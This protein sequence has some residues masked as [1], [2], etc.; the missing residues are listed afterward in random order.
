MPRSV[1]SALAV[2]LL[3]ALLNASATRA[4]DDPY[5]PKL[6]EME[7]RIEAALEKRVKCEWENVQLKDVIADLSKQVDL[8]ISFDPE[9]LEEAGAADDLPISLSA[10]TLRL[11]TALQLILGPMNLAGAVG[12]GG[13]EISSQEKVAER[14]ILRV[15]P[16]ADLI[17][18]PNAGDGTIWD[19]DSLTDAITSHVAPDAWPDGTGPGPVHGFAGCLVVAH[20]L[21]CHRDIYALLTGLRRLKQEVAKQKPGANPPIIYVGEPGVLAVQQALDKR[22]STTLDTEL[23]WY[24][25]DLAKILQ[26]PVIVDPTGLE[27]A[28]VT[29]DTKIQVAYRNARIGDAMREPLRKLRLYRLIQDGYLEITSIEKAD[30]TDYR[31]QLHAVSDFVTA[32]DAK[33]QLQQLNALGSLLDMSIPRDRRGRRGECVLT[34]WLETP[35]LIMTAS[36][37]IQ[38]EIE[39]LLDN[40]RSRGSGQH[41]KAEQPNEAEIVERIY[42]LYVDRR[43]LKA[44]LIEPAKAQPDDKKQSALP[45]GTDWL[46]QFGAMASPS[47]VVSR[48]A[49]VAEPIPT[50]DDVAKLVRELLP[51]DSW[52][53][54]GVLLRPFHDVLIIRQRRPMLRKI[55]KLL[56][57]I[58][59]CQPTPGYQLSN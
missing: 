28:G 23:K 9:G 18:S 1:L 7:A 51:D 16:V 49:K 40:L 29:L 4:D 54:E 56:I 11:V 34:P 25:K 41:L 21:R 38:R 57:D 6:T 50:A 33:G 59:A 3:L 43:A 42:K 37:D 22:D 58:D 14:P 45:H 8:P 5:A 35:A 27:E 13:L 31:T 19:Y 24:V 36:L 48:T 52:K 20:N 53:E 39:R 30:E 26:V 17:A 47:P 15:Y 12:A 55:E 44:K 32:K 10:G 46:A 2:L